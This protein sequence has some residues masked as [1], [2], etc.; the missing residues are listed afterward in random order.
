MKYDLDM[1]L[2]QLGEDEGA[3]AIFDRFLP[4]MR[5]QVGQNPMAANFSLRK[6]LAWAGDR[7]PREAGEALDR[8]L[9]EYGKTADHTPAEKVKMAVYRQIAEEDRRHWSEKAKLPEHRQDAICPGQVWLDTKGEPIQAHGGALHYENGTYYWYGENKEHTDGKSDIWTWGIRVYRST[10][11]YNWEDMGLL[12][13]PV[14]DDPDSNLFP[15]KRVDRP[16]IRRCAVTGMYVAW[17]KLSGEEACFLVMQADAFLGPYKVVRENYRPLGC[18]AG[19]FDIVQDSASGKAYLYLDAD[20]KGVLC[21]EMAEDMLSAEK[22]VSEQYMGLIP[23]FCREGIALFERG[24]RKYMLSSGMTGYIPNQSDSA[25]SEAWDTPF[26][27]KGDPY[28]DDDTLS[29]FNSQFTQVFQL[30]DRD[31]YIA[32]SDRWVPAYPVDAALADLF[33]R[34]IASRYDPIHYRA[35]PEEQAV[36]SAA[37]ML[38]TA[39]TSLADYVW[40]PLSFDGCRVRIRWQDRW[41][42][43]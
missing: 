29:S 11:L 26:I 40:L 38:E 28:V 25:V 37:P 6:L 34:C 21:L 10:D 14:L 18:K 19:D 9:R 31:L 3:A 17:I 32:L 8:A 13:P 24:G 7:L 5:Q 43:D 1:T 15:D 2:K 33:R 41:T 42:V 36:L 30:P 35:T 22:Q 23:P 12:I 16:H 20:H 27:S 4:G 39:N